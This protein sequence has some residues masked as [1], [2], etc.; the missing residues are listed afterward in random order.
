MG[1]TNPTVA[2]R[3]NFYYINFHSVGILKINIFESLASNLP[4]HSNG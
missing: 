1:R 4:V 2:E 3:V